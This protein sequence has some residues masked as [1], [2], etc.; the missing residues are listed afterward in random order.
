MMKHILETKHED[1]DFRC[2]IIVNDVASLNI[3]NS[4]DEESLICL[5]CDLVDQTHLNLTTYILMEASGVSEPS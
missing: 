2:A 1:K 3:D 5:L 4:D